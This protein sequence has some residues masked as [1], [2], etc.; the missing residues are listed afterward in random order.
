MEKHAQRKRQRLRWRHPLRKGERRREGG[1]TE[2]LQVGRKG[3]GEREMERHTGKGRLGETSARKGELN[4]EEREKQQ[5][6]QEGP[7]GGVIHAVT[8]MA[9]FML[10]HS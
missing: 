4:M 9:T 2:I 8:Q 1:V 6:D 10:K 3:R 7:D 5:R